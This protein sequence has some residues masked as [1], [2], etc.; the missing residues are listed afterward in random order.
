M[1]PDS[2]MR[3]IDRVHLEAIIHPVRL[4]A[5]PAGSTTVSMADLAE[6]LAIIRRRDLLSEEAKVGKGEHYEVYFFAKPHLRHVIENA[7]AF[8]DPIV[9][10]WYWGKLYGYSEEA[11]ASYTDKIRAPALGAGGQRIGVVV[12]DDELVV[13]GAL[14]RPP[15]RLLARCRHLLHLLSEVTRTTLTRATDGKRLDGDSR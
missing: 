14:I 9:E 11:I 8:E 1:T 7:P 6:V 3:E 2:G 15:A 5:K 4:G 12:E 10:A 13:P